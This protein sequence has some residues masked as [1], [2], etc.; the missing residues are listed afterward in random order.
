[1]SMAFKTLG[2]LMKHPTSRTAAVMD[3]NGKQVNIGYSDIKLNLTF[4]PDL[5]GDHGKYP[6]K[7]HA[8]ST[9]SHL[10]AT[11]GLIYLRGADIELYRDSDQPRTFRQDRYFFYLSGVDEPGCHILYDIS[12]RVLTLYIPRDTVF[13]IVWNGPKLTREDAIRGYDVDDVRFADT[14]ESDIETWISTHRHGPLFLLHR[15]D[16][17]ALAGE[18]GV[19]VGSRKDSVVLQGAI[20]RARLR[21][22]AHEIGLI[23]HANDITARAHRAVL[24][25]IERLDNEA[26]IEAV[27]LEACIS[28]GAKQQ[29]YEVIAA[30][31]NHASTLHYIRN[32]APLKPK[33]LVC[34]DAGCEWKCYASDVTRTFPTSGGWTDTSKAIYDIVQQ[35]QSACIKRIRPGVRFLDLQR[36]A[37]GIA[38]EGL[39]QL[40]IL[41]GGTKAEILAAKTSS[42][43][44]PHGLG[45]HLGLEVHDVFTPE[46]LGRSSSTSSYAAFYALQDPT[47]IDEDE[48]DA[49]SSLNSDPDLQI[50]DA[51]MV[52]TVEPGIYFCK[53]LIQTFTQFP[54]HARYINTNVL[55]KYWAVGGVRIED[56]V[57]VTARGYEVLSSAPK[58]RNA[59]GWSC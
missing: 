3:P 9:V 38:V 1:M 49:T 39:L 57:L 36:L 56:D 45:H 7:L 30:S 46:L 32:D 51:D 42:A 55:E 53:P 2:R 23:R 33:Q 27:F 14:V 16:L 17:M 12:R 20:D 47:A 22:S 21:K 34:L 10:K 44:F 8:S 43:F 48:A 41:H 29:A 35:M 28:R 5:R 13:S 11:H 40:G 19:H 54:R 31:G 52:V 15:D 59:F 6:A 4:E 50:L 18:T 37:H 26:Q 24:Q 25:K 58:A